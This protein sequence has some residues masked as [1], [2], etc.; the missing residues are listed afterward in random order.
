VID[1]A[2]N[3]ALDVPCQLFE[4][5][6]ELSYYVPVTLQDGWYQCQLV[7]AE[8]R[9]DHADPFVLTFKARNATHPHMPIVDSFPFEDDG[10]RGDRQWRDHFERLCDRLGVV[11]Y[12]L[13][14]DSMRRQVI[15]RVRTDE[16][17]MVDAYTCV[18]D[19]K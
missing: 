2:S 5:S 18:V 9:D 10:F 4:E 14:P 13:A 1:E 6:P 12:A 15:L 16:V 7:S 8:L 11:G 19:L 3:E 17:G